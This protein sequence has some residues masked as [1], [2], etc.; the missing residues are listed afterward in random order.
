[1]NLDPISKSVAVAATIAMGLMQVAAI[2]RQQFV[3][4]TTGGGGGRGGGGGGGANGGRGTSV[5]NVVGASEL[6][7]VAAAVAGQQEDPIRA[8]VVASEVSTV[9]ELDRNIVS[10]AS[11]G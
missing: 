5:F 6:N 7:Q 3:A 9:Q 10:E 1:M 11:I 8:Y 2:A 4:R